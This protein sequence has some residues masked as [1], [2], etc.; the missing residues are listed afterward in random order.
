M[1][2]VASLKYKDLTALMSL[3]DSFYHCTYRYFTQIAAIKMVL[4]K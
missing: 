2:H 1:Q 3:I 4:Y